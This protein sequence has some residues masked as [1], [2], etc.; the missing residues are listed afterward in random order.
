MKIV[1][2][3]SPTELLKQAFVLIA[4]PKTLRFVFL[5]AVLPNLFYYGLLAALNTSEKSLLSVFWTNVVFPFN[6]LIIVTWVI[7]FSTIYVWYSV[8]LYTFYY[9]TAL[10]QSSSLSELIKRGWQNTGRYFTSML[11]VGVYAFFGFLVFV[12]PGLFVLAWYMFSWIIAAVEEKNVEP[13]KTSKL[14]VTKAFWPIVGR[15]MLFGLLFLIPA[16]I[17]VK[18]HIILRIL[19]VSFASPYFTMLST[20]FYIDTKKTF[21]STLQPRS[22]ESKIES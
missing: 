5:F 21:L 14:M 22:K 15:A 10:G 19:W 9:Q 13:L 1:Q 6:I 18:L 7:S 20:L 16:I 17:F 3:S 2:L 4:I 8:A 11:L 12:I